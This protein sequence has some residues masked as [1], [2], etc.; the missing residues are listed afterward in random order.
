MNKRDMDEKNGVCKREIK[1]YWVSIRRFEGRE[2]A[3]QAANAEARLQKIAAAYLL[4]KHLGLDGDEKLV[5]GRFGKPESKRP[6]EFFN[7]S[8]G[9]EYVALAL[10][11]TEL[12]VD[13]EPIWEAVPELPECIFTGTE[14]EWLGENPGAES[15]CVLWTRLEALLKADGRGFEWFGRRES[16]V[17]D[18]RQWHI[19][20]IIKNGHVI[21]CAARENFRLSIGDPEIPTADEI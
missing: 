6:G 12:G 19:E 21:S 9:G 14:L 17:G 15:A 11:K 8:H 4:K 20:T 2:E 10:G 3:E 7:I 1:I 5:T 16:A 13:I 18:T